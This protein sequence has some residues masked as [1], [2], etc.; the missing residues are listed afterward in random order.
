METCVKLLVI[1]ATQQN[2]ESTGSYLP[3][4]SNPVT[5]PMS[6]KSLAFVLAAMAVEA[7]ELL[8]KGEMSVPNK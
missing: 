1:R 3:G 5:G 4:A 7:G 8:R 6:M 2:A